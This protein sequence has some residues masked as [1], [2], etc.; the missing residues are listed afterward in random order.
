M[1]RANNIVDVYAW[2]EFVKRRFYNLCM[3]SLAR[4]CANAQDIPTSVDKFTSVQ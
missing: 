3:M 2:K 4:R 1:R